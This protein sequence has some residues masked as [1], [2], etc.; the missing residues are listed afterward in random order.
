[1]V[2]YSRNNT[3]LKEMSLIQ[4]LCLPII[5]VFNPRTYWE[6]KKLI[7]TEKIDIV[8]VHNTLSLIS[9]SVYY[10]ALA[11]KVPV[12]QT[13]HNFRLLCPGA[14]FYRDGHICEDCVDQSMFCAVS[15][16]C[17]RNSRMETLICVIS[18]II[19]RFTRIYS[20]LNYI[21]LTQFN[22]EKL[23]QLSQ[24]NKTKVDVKP[25]FVQQKYAPLP[26]SNRKDQFVFAGRL[27]ALKGIDILLRAWKLAKDKYPNFN[28]RLIV[29]GTGPMEEWC[30]NY[31]LSQSLPDI[32]L[33]GYIP[34]E[35]MKKV[36]G[37]SR[38]LVLPT[39]WYEGFPMG[40]V[41]AIAQIT[42]V[43]GSNIGNVGNLINDDHNGWK[44]D[45]SS[46]ESICDAMLR[47]HD[48]SMNLTVERDKYN[49]ETN[50][51][52]LS[53]IYNDCFNRRRQ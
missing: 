11:M 33:R 4:K 32:E 43:I 34:N 3:E 25:N 41:E 51:Q 39:Q 52:M 50:Y 23:L 27:D 24:I 48:I 38:A 47:V 37:E 13:I 15:H 21:A 28:T 5:T 26:Y 6:I 49:A 46:I 31:I 8:H 45:A 40:I 29:C 35:E 17:Y 10:A 42:P 36:I 20:K 12:V 1:M 19:H 18:S 44:F 14:T 22:K 30:N 16:K 2:L 7:K 53:N 9:P